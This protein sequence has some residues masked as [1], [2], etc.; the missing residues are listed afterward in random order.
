MATYVILSQLIPGAFA[1]PKDFKKM[2]AVVSEKIKN[3]CPGITW[4]YSFA[5][6]GRFDVVDVVE[7]DDP[8]EI[9][10][11]AMIIRAYGKST[12]ETLVAAPWKEFIDAL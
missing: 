4:K 12:T 1:D 2:A 5:T 6:I 7:S 10:K 8:K 3:E 11:A 9:E